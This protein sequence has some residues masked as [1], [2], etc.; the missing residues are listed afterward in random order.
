[1]IFDNG[2]SKIFLFKVCCLIKIES[3]TGIM[4]LWSWNFGELNEIWKVVR[5]GK[6]VVSYNWICWKSLGVIDDFICRY[7]VLWKI[8]YLRMIGNVEVVK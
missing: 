6:R 2:K 3:W 5:H 1:M 7:V 4:K 8:D